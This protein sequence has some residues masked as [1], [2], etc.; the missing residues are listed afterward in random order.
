V[1]AVVTRNGRQDRCDDLVLEAAKIRTD[2]DAMKLGLMPRWSRYAIAL[3]LLI[4]RCEASTG[5]EIALQ[6]EGVMDG[7]VHAQEPLRR[8]C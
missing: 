2:S 1:P 6:V 5:D 7:G 8:C 4:G 3:P